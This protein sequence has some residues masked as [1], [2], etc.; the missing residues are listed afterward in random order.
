[1]NIFIT[2]L[3]VAM[4]NRFYAT[5]S[6]NMVGIYHTLEASVL[7]PDWPS[8][9]LTEV[10]SVTRSEYWDSRLKYTITIFP[11]VLS[12][13]MSMISSQLMVNGISC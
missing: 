6:V 12:N 2:P 10:S 3:R 1:M 8:D 9:T 5:P 11:P 13:S 7:G 4:G